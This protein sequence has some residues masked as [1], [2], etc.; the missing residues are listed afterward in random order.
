MIRKWVK[1]LAA[2]LILA[3]KGFAVANGHRQG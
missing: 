2:I 1:I 3:R